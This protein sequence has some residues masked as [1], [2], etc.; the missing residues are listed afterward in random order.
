MEALLE[1]MDEY[2]SLDLAREVMKGMREN[3]EQA[4]HTGG[5]PPYGIRVNPD[6]KQ[7]EIDPLKARAVRIYFEGVRDSVS[8]PKIAETLNDLGYRTQA[9]RKFTA[10]SFA[11]W[12]YNQKYLGNYVWNQT[13]PRD[14]DGK[15]TSR[16][17]P[18]A[19]HIIKK[20]VIPQII[21]PELFWPV[22]ALMKERQ[23]KPGRMKAKVNYLLSGK[24]ICGKCGTGYNANAYRKRKDSDEY[25]R[26]YKCSAKCGNTS[27]RKDD[28]EKLV[29]QELLLHCFSEEGITGIVANVKRLYQDHR[30]TT[31]EDVEPIQTEIRNLDTQIENWIQSLGR[32]IKGLDERIIEAQNQK[33]LLEEELNR[34]SLVQKNA[35]IDEKLITNILFTKQQE[36]LSEDEEVKKAVLFEYVDHVIIKDGGDTNNF[37]AEVTYRVLGNGAPP[38]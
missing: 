35:E 36:L 27:V 11:T 19:D 14:M 2:F 7:L 22:N 12:A 13:M 1:G 25:Y 8:L 21:E 5:K 37:K 15:R 10:N 9:G 32:G 33:E 31:K 24:I 3:A 29:I 6:T 20:G 26:Y 34:I 18:V 17:K 38:P 28:I 4:I 30:K 23:M 16:K